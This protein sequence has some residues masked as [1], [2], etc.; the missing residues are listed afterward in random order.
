MKSSLSVTLYSFES[1]PKADPQTRTGVPQ[2]AWGGDGYRLGAWGGEVRRAG[3]LVGSHPYA[4][5]GTRGLGRSS[6]GWPQEWLLLWNLGLC[7]GQCLQ[8]QTEAGAESCVHGGGEA[9]GGWPPVPVLSRQPLQLGHNKFLWK[10]LP[11]NSICCEIL[12][13]HEMWL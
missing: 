1:L 4:Q 9:G 6:R 12:K 10:G 2:A 11:F 8:H 5:W 3:S 13:C 7:Q